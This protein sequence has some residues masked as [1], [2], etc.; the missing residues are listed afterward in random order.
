[1]GDRPPTHNNVVCYECG[2][3]SHIKP[4]YPKLKGSVR[5][6][7]IRTEDVPDEGGNMEVEQ[8]TPNEYQ[9]EIQDDEYHPAATQSVEGA[10]DNWVEEPSQYN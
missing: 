10:T 8:E 3:T 2:Q 9:G 5:I 4:N 1:M 6:A 7:A